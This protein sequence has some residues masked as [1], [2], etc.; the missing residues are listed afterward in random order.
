VPKDK[1]YML[2]TSNFQMDPREKVR[3]LSKRIL[4]LMRELEDN[5]QYTQNFVDSIKDD[6]AYYKRQIESLED[7]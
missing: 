6:I 1:F 3:L 5:P 7:Q 2:T 4:A